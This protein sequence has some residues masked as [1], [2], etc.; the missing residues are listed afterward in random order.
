MFVVLIST[1]LI[2]LAKNGMTPATHGPYLPFSAQTIPESSTL[3]VTVTRPARIAIVVCARCRYAQCFPR[4][5]G[6]GTSTGPH[7]SARLLAGERSRHPGHR[8]TAPARVDCK[9]RISTGCPR[10]EPG[11][12]MKSRACT[13]N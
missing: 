10:D 11:L 2:F 7:S 9:A 4:R 13:Q 1:Q 5:S 12:T 8:P 3:S 6:T